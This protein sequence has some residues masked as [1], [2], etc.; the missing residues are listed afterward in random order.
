MS[1]NALPTAI[2]GPCRSRR[3]VGNRPNA[4]RPGLT[5]S[6]IPHPSSFPRRA[7]TLVELL[8]VV[9]IIGILVGMIMPAVQQARESGRKSVCLNNLRNIGLALQQYE[10]QNRTLPIGSWVN[11]ANSAT[12]S[13]TED[14]G[15]MLHFILP[16][17]GMQT[18]YDI[19]DWK[20][21]YAANDGSP[22]YRPKPNLHNGTYWKNPNATNV[23]GIPSYTLGM[24]LYSIKIASFVCPSDDL[25][26]IY[27]N[28]N[29]PY[30]LSNYV[31]SA[32]SVSQSQYDSGGCSCSAL[33]A[34]DSWNNWL[35]LAQQYSLGLMSQRSSF[36]G[37][38]GPF[39][40][41]WSQTTSPRGGY[42]TLPAGTVVYPAI[43]FAQIRDGL[44]STIMCGETRATCNSFVRSGW[45]ESWN[46]CAL[47]NTSYP[48]NYDT[49]DGTNSVCGSTP[50]N[51]SM[52]YTIS[53]GFKSAHFGG[54]NFVFCDAS[55]HWL[56]QSID[57]I[58]YQCLGAIDDGQPVPATAIP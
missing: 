31:A 58:I 30:A 52:N 10:A 46:G 44:S 20:D 36:G 24:P 4:V 57:P 1:C 49:C 28:G 40:R 56:T 5:S 35:N 14:G 21:V 39:M 18:L 33:T 2:G 6:V 48:M 11:P 3:I 15:S 25:R 53:T 19:F 43:S 13:I 37:N 32:G 12:T 26:G 38:T 27:L 17:M 9:A 47:I 51:A 41:H 55:T 22:T 8:V 34:A 16:H 42:G 7:F 54:C 23:V 50:C 45:T 29:T